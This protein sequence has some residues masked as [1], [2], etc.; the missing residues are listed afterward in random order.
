MRETIRRAV[1]ECERN[2]L[3]IGMSRRRFL[4]SLCGAATTLL[5]LN[6]CTRDALKREPGGR[7]NVSPEATLDEDAARETLGGDEF[8]FDIQGHLLEYDL[9]PTV[10]SEGADF[11]SL[12]PQQNCG[13]DDPATATRSSSSSS[14]CSFAA[15]PRRS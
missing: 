3:R 9:N 6:S 4:L 15:I 12:F 7:Y 13:A 2:A 14:S 5:T 8:I 1:D 11:W 10:N